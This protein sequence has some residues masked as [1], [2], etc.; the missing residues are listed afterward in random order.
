MKVHIVLTK[1]DA[2]IICFK[3]SL[4]KGKFNE[5]VIKILRAAVRNKIAVMPMSFKINRSVPK[6]NTKIDLPQ[7]LIQDCYEKLGF[8]K[9]CFTTG[10]KAE[11]RKC[12]RKNLV[13]KTD[14]IL[15]AAVQKMFADALALAEKQKKELVDDGCSPALYPYREAMDLL[16]S[17]IKKSISEG[18]DEN[19]R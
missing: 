11:I 5:T 10:V 14:R 2:D 16:L 12:I 9:G 15:L 18:G 13:T 6:L 17:Q 1:Q 3:H 4:P 19:G 8:K 7:D